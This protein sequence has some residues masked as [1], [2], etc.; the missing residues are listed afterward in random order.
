MMKTVR[1]A[2]IGAGFIG[3]KHLERLAADPRAVLAAVCEQDK[4]RLEKASAAFSPESAFRSTEELRRAGG[5]EAAVLALPTAYRRDLT[6]ELL[7]DGVHLLLEK[8][9]S[10]NAA[11]ARLFGSRTRPDQVVACASSRFSGSRA[12]AHGREWI[13]QGRIGRL[14]MIRCRG[15]LPARAVSGAALPKWRIRREINGGGILSNWGT[16]DLDFLVSLSGW[17]AESARLQAWI[18]GIHPE[19]EAFH[20][21]DSNVESHAVVLVE[22]AEGVLLHYE[23]AETSTARADSLWEV[24]G[25]RGSVRMD[26]LHPA[27]GVTLTLLDPGHGTREETARFP[28][29]AAYDAHAVPLDN[30]LDAILHGAEPL[31]GL[32]KTER[33]ARLIDAAYCSGNGEFL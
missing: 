1:I 11:D 19:A 31:T 5:F 13:R 24:L 9:G 29:D 10:L 25:T 33:I 26:M 23:R 16:Y 4:N 2:V 21:P 27:E 14:R 32:E 6:L 30:F 15:I 3:W 28:E 20:I 12:L 18:S 7:D 22:D 17:E 8:P